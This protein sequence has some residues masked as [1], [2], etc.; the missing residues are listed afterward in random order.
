MNW[1]R[2]LFGKPARSIEPNKGAS[3]LQCSQCGRELEFIGN[4]M[5]EAMAGGSSI[6]ILG[7]GSLSASVA[8]SDQWKGVVC[9]HCRKAFCTDCMIS[10]PGPC[11]LCG[12]D[13]VPATR[14]YVDAIR[15]TAL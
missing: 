14:Q 10:A 11:P 2:R 15:R 5:N 3:G 7:S 9:M 4:W 8:A 13:I 6:T 1:L 12:Q